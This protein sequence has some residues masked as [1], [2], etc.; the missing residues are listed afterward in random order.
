MRVQRLDVNLA[1]EMS[2]VS[3]AAI[4]L[5]CNDTRVPLS[6]SS[7]ICDWS[8]GGDRDVLRLRIT[9]DLAEKLLGLWRK[10]PV[11]SLSREFRPNAYF[12]YGRTFT[13]LAVPAELFVYVMSVCL[14][15]C[16]DVV[17]CV[18]FQIVTPRSFFWFLHNLAHMIHVPIRT[19]LW[20]R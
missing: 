9:V 5:L 13:F 18:F 16:L 15:V 17:K 10:S 1:V 6:S 4:P 14:D 7:I 19:K 3:P 11:R 20:N 12:K 8:K 2:R